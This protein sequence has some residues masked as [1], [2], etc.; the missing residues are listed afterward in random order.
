MLVRPPAVAGRFYP[1]EP[2]RLR[3]GVEGCL[4]EAEDHAAEAVR[5]SR[6]AAL[7]VPHAGYKFSGPVAA[8][9]YVRLAR[10]ASVFSRV[11]LLGT[12]HTPGIEGLATTEVEAFDTPLGRVPVDRPALETVLGLPQV[13]VHE[14]AQLR[15]HA[16]E[17]QLPFL[18][19]V[20]GAFAIVPFLVGRA[21]PLAVAEVLDRL[22][23]G[24]STLIVVSSD[25]SHDHPCEEAR[26]LDL[27]TAAAI[28]QLDGRALGAGSACG[29]V[30]IAGLLEAARRRELRCRTVDLRSSAD[31]AG[32]RERVVGYGAFVFAAARC[33]ST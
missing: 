11:V 20:L 6:P 9:G 8:S 32:P 26:R 18:Q 5:E 19:V 24:D 4:A 16:L 30:A 14:G 29:R 21:D 7:I 15:D 10:W 1:A 33:A 23:D 27:A 3:E 13:G 25:L 22:W 2:D 31:T 12:C 17:V 28:E